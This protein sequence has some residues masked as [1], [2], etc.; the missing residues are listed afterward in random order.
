MSQPEQAD[1]D[2]QSA[3]VG[4]EPAETEPG[5]ENQ[6]GTT[7]NDV[8]TKFELLVDTTEKYTDDGQAFDIVH[9]HGILGFGDKWSIDEVNPWLKTFLNSKQKLARI[10]Y[11]GYATNDT[12][13]WVY[14]AEAIS[15]EARKLLKKIAAL[16]KDQES[17]RPLA[18]VGHNLGGIIIKQ[19]M[20]LAGQYPT[21]FVD[22][23]SST[24]FLMFLC[25]PHRWTSTENMEDT[26]SRLLH[27][28]KQTSHISQATKA[29]ANSIIRINNS[30]VQT[31]LL[32]RVAVVNM[33]ASAD[34][35]IDMFIETLGIPTELRMEIPNYDL[36]TGAPGSFGEDAVDTAMDRVAKFPW[37]ENEITPF[38]ALIESKAPPIYP[39]RTSFGPEHHLGWLDQNPI[40]QNF[41][42]HQGMSILHIYGHPQFSDAAE[43]GFQKLDQQRGKTYNAELVLYFKFDRHDIRRNSIRAMATA[44]LSQIFSRHRSSPATLVASSY[45]VPDF[46]NC[47]TEQDVFHYLNR[48][49]IE[50]GNT[51]RICWVLDGLDQ[52]EESSRSWFLSEIVNIASNSEAPLR[53]LITSLGGGELRTALNHFPAI[54]LSDHTSDIAPAEGSFERG[55]LVHDLANGL[56]QEFHSLRGFQTE[57][58]QLLNGC[59]VD[60][61]LRRILVAWFRAVIPRLVKKSAIEKE[62][63]ELSPLSPKKIFKRFLDSAG[64]NAQ[65]R[66]WAK[67]LVEWVTFAF[68]PLTVGELQSAL[69]VELGTDDEAKYD[70]TDFDGF[71][72]EMQEYLGPLLVVD[73]GEVRF[74]HPEARE[75]FLPDPHHVQKAGISVP[76]YTVDVEENCHQRH[77]STCFDILDSKWTLEQLASTVAS[78]GDDGKEVY[79]AINDRTDLSSYA[80]HFWPMH[81]NLSRRI[82]SKDIKI[83]KD[84]DGLRNW[85]ATSSHFFESQPLATRTPLEPLSIFSA[86][87]LEKRVL[88]FQEAHKMSEPSEELDDQVASALT[89]AARHGQSQIV[90]ILLKTKW[91]SIAAMLLAMTSAAYGGK[92]GTLSVILDEF[93]AKKKNDD[94]DDEDVE[95][96]SGLLSRVAWFGR[97]EETTVASSRL[98]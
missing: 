2:G 91:V 75:V 19:A 95:W 11:Y 62:L 59:G 67:R 48:I 54:D 57:L 10:I 44:F 69:K 77:V 49:R 36:A 46:P 24:R 21:E 61:A 50:S 15:E 16:R 68:R 38:V 93:I 4:G 53:L 37:V 23:R 96:P 92:F 27:F 87:G 58:R 74:A 5:A 7:D 76:W 45:P 88:E 35:P 8:I 13:R 14:T 66:G 51:S 83:L 18:F 63:R 80:I 39:Q 84:R 71:I 30:F 20:V 73:N 43:Y 55:L 26:C 79:S 90:N 3:P 98:F 64:G 12:A 42:S 94:V 29:L 17:P 56:I 52:C 31:N 1:Q 47:W 6:A 65:R 60:D 86:L 34:R 9:V 28:A 81:Y 40:F 32:A 97:G 33:Y 72:S 78:F 82:L 85:S 41:V 89:E 22:I 70:W 25:C